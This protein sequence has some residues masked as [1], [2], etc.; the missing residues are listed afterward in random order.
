[1][2]MCT[3]KLLPL[4]LLLTVFAACKKKGN[5]PGG[6]YSLSY[7]DSVIY[8]KNTGGDYIVQP[9]TPMAGTY[10]AFP[11]GI[12]LDESTGAINVSK[13]E[14]GLRYRISFTPAGSNR[15]YST[16]VLLAGINYLDAFY[17]LSKNDTVSRAVYNGDLSKAI[18][19]A[20]GKTVFDVDRGCNNEGIAVNVNDGSINLME[21]IRSGFFGR[22]RNDDEEEFELVYKIDDKSQQARQSVK[23]KLYYYNT[24]ADVP[25]KYWDLLKER[26]GTLLWANTTQ[27]PTGELISGVAGVDGVS[28]RARPR[29]P[30]IFIIAR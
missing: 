15:S 6:D 21:T 7:G 3:R 1:M 30:C 16:V 24:L 26:E 8:L 22:H 25:Q 17:F 10:T 12:E 4:L 27:N 2:M 18:P 9:A 23:I 11:E 29:P 20:A 19:V 13:S 28:G 14:T 5:E